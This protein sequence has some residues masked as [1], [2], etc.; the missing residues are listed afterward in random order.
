MISLDIY[1]DPICPWCFI[2][3]ARLDRALENRPDHPFDIRWHPFQ[4]NP[5]MPPKAWRATPIWP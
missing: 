5:D 1:S 4:L 2:G 3:K